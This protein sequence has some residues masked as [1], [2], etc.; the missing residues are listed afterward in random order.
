MTTF[1]EQ[2]AD[3]GGW[4]GYSG[5]GSGGR[6]ETR[7]AQRLS[8]TLS[9]AKRTPGNGM[10]SRLVEAE[11]VPYLAQSRGPVQGGSVDATGATTASDPVI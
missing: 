1:M 2:I 8:D 3:P 11:I 10:L 7:F 9:E 5:P 4:S 6:A